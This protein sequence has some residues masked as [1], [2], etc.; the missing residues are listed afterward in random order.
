MKSFLEEY[1]IVIVVAIV[2]IALI[3]LAVVFS[4]DAGVG[5]ITGF[6]TQFLDQGNIADP[7]AGGGAGGEGGGN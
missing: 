3:G 1:G 7:L 4:G 2:I 5:R 6:L